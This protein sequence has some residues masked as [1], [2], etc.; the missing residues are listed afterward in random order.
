MKYTIYLFFLCSLYSYHTYGQLKPIDKKE[1]LL[2]RTEN[3][4]D[5]T[6]IKNR[7]KNTNELVS[8]CSTTLDELD[9]AYLFSRPFPQVKEACSRPFDAWMLA[10]AEAKDLEQIIVLDSALMNLVGLS[11]FHRVLGQLSLGE[12]YMKWNL[13]PNAF[14]KFIRSLKYATH[15]NYLKCL[16]YL[17]LSELFHV[18]IDEVSEWKYIQMAKELSAELESSFLA[19]KV[20]M[21]IRRYLVSFHDYPID[22]ALMYADSSIQ[23]A[24]KLDNSFFIGTAYNGI[25]NIY[26][27]AENY[28]LAALYFERAINEFKKSG[29]SILL[30]Y[31]YNNVGY[32]Y[33]NQQKLEQ[34]IDYT[35]QSLDLLN[36]AD[37]NDANIYVLYLNLSELYEE[38]GAYDIALSYYKEFDALEFDRINESQQKELSRLHEIY[39]TKERIEQIEKLKLNAELGKLKVL[40]RTN[41]RNLAITGGVAM[42]I[43]SSLI[44]YLLIQKRQRA[45]AILK[46]EM[47]EKSK[48]MALLALESEN[49]SIRA[50]TFGQESERKRI[51]RYLHDNIGNRM[52]GIKM[53]L[54]KVAETCNQFDLETEDLNETYKIVEDTAQEIRGLSHELTSTQNAPFSLAENLERMV[55][56]YN[57]SKYL[58]VKLSLKGQTN[59]S[60]YAGL[61]MYRIAQEAITNAFKYSQ[62]EL[63]EV[64]LSGDGSGVMLSIKDNGVG[65]NPKK[66]KESN[67]LKNM[68]ERA[69]ALNA[70]L[71]ITSVPGIGTEV[72]V[73]LLFYEKK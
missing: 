56:T 18:Q 46:K 17:S 57:S 70:D 22:S 16:V 34:A 53:R 8:T 26:E 14:N 66:V 48:K 28:D 60:S 10:L 7:K 1:L 2:A 24:K 36:A 20:N 37:S 31:V 29:D 3:I 12:R 54:S 35:Q 52:G 71:N 64:M 6:A 33:S 40:K 49:A 4:Y 11:N 63:V 41:Q 39:K 21:M 50:I 51:A 45:L 23:Y 73:K 42:L 47:A 30:A 43:I 55:S 19:F 38:Q 65:F 5:A 32:M 69:S 9:V 25:G 15:N 67:G 58:T 44:A 13:Y 68:K 27:E 72:I 61:E 59:L 62:S